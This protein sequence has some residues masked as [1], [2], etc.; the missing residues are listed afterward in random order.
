MKEKNA[1]QPYFALKVDNDYIL[2]K[3][4]EKYTGPA[5]LDY[6]KIKHENFDI[7]TIQAGEYKFTKV[8]LQ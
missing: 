2:E 6:T 8:L 3:I 1:E 5:I 7:S 4:E